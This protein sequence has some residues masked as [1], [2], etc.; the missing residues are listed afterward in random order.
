MPLV[1]VTVAFPV[2]VPKQVTLFCA[3]IFAATGNGIVNVNEQV[4]TLPFTSVTV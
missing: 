2:A 1:A 3:V 4:L